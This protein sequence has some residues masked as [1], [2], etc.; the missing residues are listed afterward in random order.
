MLAPRCWDPLL[1]PVAGTHGWDFPTGIDV[2][3]DG[4]PLTGDESLELDE[5]L[6][7]GVVDL[8]EKGAGELL[9]RRATVTSTR[10]M[11]VRLRLSP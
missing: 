6:M 5:Q 2:E 8:G 10:M 9:L 7:T 11:L 3:V 4:D 1:G